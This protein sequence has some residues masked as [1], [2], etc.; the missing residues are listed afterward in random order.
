MDAQSKYT[1]VWENEEFFKGE[2]SRCSSRESI[3]SWETIQEESDWSVNKSRMRK[4]HSLTL[5][6][7]RENL[8]GLLNSQQKSYDR[9]TKIN[10]N[11]GKLLVEKR[12]VQCSLKA[13]RH[14][15][16]LRQGKVWKWVNWH[17]IRQHQFE[18]RWRIHHR[19]TIALLNSIQQRAQLV[20]VTGVGFGELQQ[21][22]NYDGTMR[23]W[24]IRLRTGCAVKCARAQARHQELL[25][26]RNVSGFFI[27]SLFPL[28]SFFLGAQSGCHGSGRLSPD[29]R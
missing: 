8:L 21:G 4:I 24:L 19:V 17:K 3:N 5:E 12:T 10:A 15:I 14:Q 18:S 28:M 27:L 29:R 9:F 7:E 6:T 25:K 13:H 1:F 11:L 20:D 16:S 23:D 2:F 26:L 22:P